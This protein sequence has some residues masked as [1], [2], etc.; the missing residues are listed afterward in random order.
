[1]TAS[2]KNQSIPSALDFAEALRHEVNPQIDPKRKAEFGQFFT[3]L[4]IARLMASMIET[5]AEQVRI[6]DAGAGVGCLFAA[7]VSQLCRKK[8]KPKTIHVTA[9]EIDGQFEP[10]LQQV[11]QACA[12]ECRAAGIR[13][14]AAVLIGDFLECAVENN[15]VSLFPADQRFDLAILNPPY[16]KIHSRSSIR[17][18]LQ[19][20]GIETTNIYTGF[21]TVAAHLL[22]PGGELIAITPRSFCNGTYFHKFRKWFLGEVPLRR[23]HSFVSRE[24]AFREDEVLQE[25]VIFRAVKGAQPDRIMVTSS[26]GPSDP[27]MT[28]QDVDYGQVVRPDD[29][30]VFIRILT[31]DLAR[32]IAARMATCRM[33]LADLGLTVSTGRVVDFRAR[34]YLRTE[35]EKNTVP[36]I[37]Q[38][39]FVG[40]YIMW[41]KEGIRKPEHFLSA[42]AVADQLVPNEPYVL[43]R[44]FS[45]KEER[46]RIVAAVYD[47]SRLRCKAVGFENHLNYFHQK[48]RGLDMQL[49]RGL[50]AFLNSTLVDQYFR[51]FSG[52]TQ[53]NATD[54]RN[55]RYPTRDQLER[56]GSVIGDVFPDQAAIDSLVARELFK[57]DPLVLTL[58]FRVDGTSAESLPA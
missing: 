37:W 18:S 32:Q 13:F 33:T 6:L 15:G 44:R 41:P 26:T 4:P 21:L 40:G 8:W 48:G 11:V 28:S 29:P 12:G 3:V 14:T 42:E 54:L 51:Q 36:L 53:V 2:R 46:R 25:T 31:D 49:A 43:V 1:M 30:Q 35:A 39:H 56:M 50:A 58:S 7:A 45:A 52:H 23:L 47:A 34:D 22:V 16:F 24:D 5:E 9:H 17:K 38:A 10:R 55:L 19:R 20:A 27:T 57:S